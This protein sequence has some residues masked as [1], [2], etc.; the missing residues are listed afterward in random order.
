MKLY[1]NGCSFTYGDDLDNPEKNSWPTAVSTKLGF[2]FLNDAV[3]GGTNER[4]IYKTI[5][6]I[7]AY[8]YFFIAWTEYARFTKYNPIDNYEINFTPQLSLD[9]SLHISDDLKINYSKYK[10]Y[11]ELYYKHW[12]NELFEFKKWLQQI[13]MLQSVFKIRRKKYLM[14]NT[15]HNHLSN[16]LSPQETFIDEVKNLLIFFDYISDPQLMQEHLQ[17][18]NL[19]AMID[20]AS[21]VDWNYWCIIDETQKHP[22]GKKGHILE[23]GHQAVANKV[24]NHYNKNL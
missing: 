8:D 23:D 9:P 6:N 16:W 14:I 18:Q 12:F 17:I 4:T 3:S 10:N 5:L 20:T 19:V 11:G 13:I 7:D 1:F 15:F 2:S 22:I 21:F 24:I